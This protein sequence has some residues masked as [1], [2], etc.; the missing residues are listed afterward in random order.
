LVLQT[1]VEPGFAAGVDDWEAIDQLH[2]SLV[3]LPT[4]LI[5]KAAPAMRRRRWGRVI[6]LA[7]GNDGATAAVAVQ[8]A[9]SGLMQAEAR[10]LAAEGITV[11]LI[12]VT[13]ATFALTIEAKQALAA[14]ALYFASAESS[15]VTGQT[16]QLDGDA[17]HQ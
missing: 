13:R 6:F 1:I 9:Q 12:A 16:L 7:G 4:A 14:A 11:N 10:R 5:A 15:F 17:S 3:T 8:T 2:R